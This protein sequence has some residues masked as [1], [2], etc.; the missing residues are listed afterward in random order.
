MEVNYK[1]KFSKRLIQLRKQKGFTQQ[2]FA[3]LLGISCSALSYYE[4]DKRTINIELL[5]KIADFFNVSTDYLLGR[6]D[7]E[8]VNEDMQTACKVTGLSESAV[9]AIRKVHDEDPHRKLKCDSKYE[10][11]GKMLCDFILTYWGSDRIEL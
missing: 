1:E 7:V 3:D 2:Q 4:A 11:I 5:A 9:A 8:S 6:T 10:T